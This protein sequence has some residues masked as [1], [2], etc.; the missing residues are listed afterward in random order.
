MLRH[1]HHYIH[2]APISTLKHSMSPPAN[3]YKKK[4]PPSSGSMIIE[5]PYKKQR[6]HLASG[7]T[8][9]DGH[10]ATKMHH[11]KSIDPRSEAAWITPRKDYIS[12][13]NYDDGDRK[14]LAGNNKK[15]VDGTWS[16]RAANPGER[17][18]NDD[19]VPTW[20]LVTPATI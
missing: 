11:D 7:A 5:N 16:M 9:T 3:P 4:P 19:Q 2:V 17:G 10:Q 1:H 18:R 12:R 20:G 6:G 15:N 13:S 8:L 14:Q